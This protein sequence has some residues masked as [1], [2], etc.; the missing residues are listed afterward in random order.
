MKL[1]LAA[2]LSVSTAFAAKN[3]ATT[4]NVD[5]QATQV[6]WVG[7]KVAGPHNGYVNVKS[8]TLTATADGKITQGNI[9]VDMN[10]LT[11]TDLTDKEWND[12]LVGHLKAPDFFDTEKYPEAILVIRSSK[13]TAKGL[14]VVGDLTI[15]GIKQPV[16]FTATEVKA[17]PDTYTAKATI[18]VDRTKHGVV[19]NAGKGDSSLIKSLGDKLIYDDFTLN[20]TLAAKK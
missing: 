6:E 18:T 14:D 16:K 11:N 8:G 1:L 5:T 9:I 20:I 10:S 4:Y 19:Y 3:T 7:K 17:T 12:K 13:K 15:K 2:V